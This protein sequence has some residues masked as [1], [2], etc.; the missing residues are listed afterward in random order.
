MLDAVV[1]HSLSTVELEPIFVA[2]HARVDTGSCIWVT[3]KW[4]WSIPAHERLVHAFKFFFRELWIENLCSNSLRME[5]SIRHALEAEERSN[6]Y[7]VSNF[8]SI[9]SL[10][11]KL[12]VCLLN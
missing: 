5:K 10:Q 9:Y 6:N 7:Y 12:G 11:Q 8:L 4:S 1:V 2:Q 3:L